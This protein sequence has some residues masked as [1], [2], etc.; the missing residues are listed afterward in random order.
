MR[1]TSRIETA[2]HCCWRR[3]AT[4]T[5][6][7]AMSSLMPPMPV[8]SSDRPS[9][10][11]VNGPLRSSNVQIPP[12][13]SSSCLAGGG[14]SEPSLGST[15]TAALPRTSKHPSKA[16]RAGS[17]SPPS[18]CSDDGS[19]GAD[20]SSEFRVRLLDPLDC[21]A[22]KTPQHGFGTAFTLGIHLFLQLTI[23]I[24]AMSGSAS[25]GIFGPP[26][27]PDQINTFAVD[28]TFQDGTPLVGTIGLGSQGCSTLRRQ[29]I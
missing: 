1:P 25:A 10:G 20:L 11:S 6:G 8:R 29:L 4:L 17:T 19:P 15:A 2:H 22:L 14:S 3:S 12:R 18:S 13:G 24:L 26:P 23:S 28:G 7:C 21:P 27:P 16:P 9:R 5:R